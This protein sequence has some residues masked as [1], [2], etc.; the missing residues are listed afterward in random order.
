MD[1]AANAPSARGPYR[2]GVEHRAQI[3]RSASEAFATLGYT[4]GSLRTI[5]GNVGSTSAALIQL[6]GSKEA[7]LMAVL[8][9]WTTQNRDVVIAD[10]DGLAFFRALGGLM[11]FHLQHRGLLELFI[12]LAAEASNP[13]HPAHTFIRNRYAEV[14][15]EWSEHLR[16]ARD[17]GEIA[18]LTERQISSEIH[19]LLAVAD[20]LELQWLLR[21]EIDL[22]RLFGTYLS[23]AIHRWQ[24]GV[25]D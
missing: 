1:R 23:A 4:G 17:R 2:R 13:T 16:V 8:E 10:R 24:S 22:P 5:A 19:T 11:E 25:G 9:D 7:L 21:P 15:R 3:V 6:F 18:G 20:G 12:T 14:Q